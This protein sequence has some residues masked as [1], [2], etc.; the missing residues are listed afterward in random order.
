MH[1]CAYISICEHYRV[2]VIWKILYPAMN[3]ASLVR[4]C[5]PEP[6]TPTNKALPPGVRI[7]LDT[8]THKT[9]HTYKTR[10]NKGSVG[11]QSGRFCVSASVCEQASKHLKAPQIKFYWSKTGRIFWSLK[12][13]RE[14]PFNKKR[15]ILHIC[16][17]ARDTTPMG[18]S[19]SRLCLSLWHLFFIHVH[20]NLPNLKNIYLPFHNA[21][22][23]IL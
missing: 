16:R 1:V 7:I 19:V 17:V 13:V 12:A 5:L 2:R 21:F 4:L 14:H 20:F 18:A 3:E 8:Y 15:I 11:K 9:K 23:S 6:P 22:C 10:I